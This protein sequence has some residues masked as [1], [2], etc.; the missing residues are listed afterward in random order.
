MKPFPIIVLAAT[1]LSLVGC[2]S[3]SAPAVVAPKMVTV[4]VLDNSYNPQSIQINRGDTVRWVLAGAA[5]TH[6]VTAL[7]GT[8]DSTAIF[9]Q[10]GDTYDQTFNQN[11]ATFEYFCQAHGAC[12]ACTMK[13]SVRVGPTAP[14]PN[15]GY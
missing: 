9:L 1:F 4:E 8:F 12:M 3:S 15:P 6:T 13:G 5:P 7:G 14:T 2:K 10:A 11:N